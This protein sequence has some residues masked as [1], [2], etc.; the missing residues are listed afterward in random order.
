[1]N[2]SISRR[3]F[4]E[5]AALASALVAAEPKIATVDDGNGSLPTAAS[6]GEHIVLVKD[7]HIAGT[8][9]IVGIDELVAGLAVGQKLTFVRE[10]H[11]PHDALAIR[12]FAGDDRLGFVPRRQNE[13]I[14]RMM[15]SGKAIGAKIT[16]IEKL[17]RWNK[18]HMEVFLDDEG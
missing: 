12:V 17:G 8:M 16:G 14:A 9:H 5:L 13:M 1:M 10:P 6:S 18:I 3:V 7:M 11:N 2:E 4:F 15:D